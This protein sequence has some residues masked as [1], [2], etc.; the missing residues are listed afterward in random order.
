MFH[1]WFYTSDVS[2]RAQQIYGDNPELWDFSKKKGA[3]VVVINLGTNDAN[4][5]N[6]V[7]REEYLE[8][9]RL[10]IMG[11]HAVWPEAKI[12]SIVSPILNFLVVL[13]EWTNTSQ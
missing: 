10:L 6:G 2:W 7:G 5:H 4:A 13:G 3:D 11:V 8:A 9:Y 12:V 1:Q